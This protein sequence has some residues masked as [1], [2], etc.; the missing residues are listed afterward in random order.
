M[1]HTAVDP[2]WATLTGCCSNFFLR[3]FRLRFPEFRRV[4]VPTGT[5]SSTR[6]ILVEED[7][8]FRTISGK[9]GYSPCKGAEFYLRKQN[10][11]RKRRNTVHYDTIEK[12]PIRVGVWGGVWGVRSTLL[13][14]GSGSISTDPTLPISTSGIK[15][16]AR[17]VSRKPEKVKSVGLTPIP[18]DL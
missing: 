6:G 8:I 3:C 9:K 15:R 13:T 11:P 16:K 10:L 14:K 17:E 7:N 12:I 1:T 18:S 2:D 4:H 5:P